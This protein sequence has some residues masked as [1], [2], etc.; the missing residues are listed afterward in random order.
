MVGRAQA[1]WP[2]ATLT[3]TR[4]KLSLDV[5]LAGNFVFKPGDIVSIEPTGWF[6][7]GIKINHTVSQYDDKVI[8][9]KGN[10]SGLIE[11]IEQMGFLTNTDP[12]DPSLDQQIERAQSQ[13]AFTF[14][15]SA[16]IVIAL[17]YTGLIFWSFKTIFTGGIGFL[18]P[19]GALVV[20]VG[21]LFAVCVLLLSAVPVRR[22]LLKDGRTADDIKDTAYFLMP[23]CVLMFLMIVITARFA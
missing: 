8:F 23:I 22:I 5:V 12:I 19:L 17:V 6:N 21:F 13:G 10:P 3:V 2:L 14:K 16:A 4:E 7:S 18:P 15:V 9:S 1:S 11:K 20:P